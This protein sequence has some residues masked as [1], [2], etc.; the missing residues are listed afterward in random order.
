[1][2]E[3]IFFDPNR[4]PSDTHKAFKLFCKRFELRYNAQFVDPPRTAMDSAIQR[5]ELQHPATEENLR[6]KPTVDEFDAMKELWKNKD[7]VNK[8]LGIRV[9]EAFFTLNS[10]F[11]RTH[12]SVQV[13]FPNF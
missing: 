9:A 5:W 7:K 8:V 3:T 6:P 4:H 13:H 2:E 1:M 11:I 12:C 10:E